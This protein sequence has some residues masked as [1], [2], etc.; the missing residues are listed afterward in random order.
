MLSGWN[1]KAKSLS[2]RGNSGMDKKVKLG[3]KIVSA[4]T[5]AAVRK[6]PGMSNA[7]K[8]PK[9]KDFAGKNGTFPIETEKH[10]KSA[11]KLAHN[12]IVS[13][14]IKQKVYAKYPHLKPRGTHK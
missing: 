4:K 8:H 14:T 13:S 9:V 12:A 3:S 2:F 7:G 10:A 5:A 6:K 11:L 1:H